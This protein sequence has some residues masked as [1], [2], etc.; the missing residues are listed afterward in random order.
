MPTQA[1]IEGKNVHPVE[2]ACEAAKRRQAM[3][4]DASASYPTKDGGVPQ[5]CPGDSVDSVPV[6]SVK[7]EKPKKAT[8]KKATA[9]K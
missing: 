2:V 1:E 8:A 9:K 3:P 4:P 5:V 6:A 7:D